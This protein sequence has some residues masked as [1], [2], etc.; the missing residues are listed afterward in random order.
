MTLSEILK[1]NSPALVALSGGTDS[2]TLLAAFVKERLPVS[3]IT[4]RS[5]FTVPEEVT[6][7]EKFARKLGVDWTVI[8]VSVLSDER[9][10]FNPPNR[11]Y[12]CKKLIMT[13]LLEFADG[14]TVC[15]GT[16][17]D[18]SAEDRPGRKALMELGIISPFALAG[19]GK[20]EIYSLAKELGVTIIPSSSCLATRIP[21]GEEVTEDNMKKIAEAELFL[22]EKGISEMLRVRLSSGHAVIETEKNE[23]DKAEL[24]LDDLKTFGFSTITFTEYKTGGENSWN[25]IQQ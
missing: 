12:I 23:R 10:W 15:D 16:H 13:A 19:I 7:A 11:C 21:F 17:A 4:I 1:E 2:M 8:D 20:K 18:D 25:K 3:A 5:E 14:K 24:Y 6:R 9:L 22:R